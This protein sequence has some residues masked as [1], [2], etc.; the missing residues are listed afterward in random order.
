MELLWLDHI[1]FT[2][3]GDA[4]VPE[5]RGISGR[6]VVPKGSWDAHGSVVTRDT[7][8]SVARHEV[9]QIPL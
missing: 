2:S 4:F 8:G 3:T 9:L 1:V 5:I 7:S 6:V